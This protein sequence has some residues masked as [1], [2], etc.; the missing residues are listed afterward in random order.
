MAG[1]EGKGGKVG[2]AH[3]MPIDTVMGVGNG[4]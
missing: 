2:Y 1:G 4:S 3:A